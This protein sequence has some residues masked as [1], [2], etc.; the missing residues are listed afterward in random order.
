M[1]LEN[2]LI[3]L[4]SQELLYYNLNIIMII[5]IFIFPLYYFIIL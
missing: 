5:V 2:N 1:H 4:Y 3:F